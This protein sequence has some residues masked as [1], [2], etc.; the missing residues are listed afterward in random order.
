MTHYTIE[1]SDGFTTWIHNTTPNFF[2]K[3]NTFE[4]ARDAAELLLQCSTVTKYSIN[5]FQQEVIRVKEK[6]S[7]LTKKV[8]SKVGDKIVFKIQFESICIPHKW[9]DTDAEFNNLLH[10]QMILVSE[11]KAWPD[12]SF[13]L[14]RRDYYYEELMVN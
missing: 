14:V 4:E 8:P 7:S 3:Y 2:K 6:E 9:I 11:Q 5:K 1:L 12:R 13:R 10:A